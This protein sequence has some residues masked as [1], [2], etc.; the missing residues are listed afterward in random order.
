MCE[1][2]NLSTHR[3]LIFNIVSVVAIILE[4]F[5]TVKCCPVETTHTGVEND[6]LLVSIMYP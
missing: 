5:M 2:I 1:P 4:Q 6:G 3:I